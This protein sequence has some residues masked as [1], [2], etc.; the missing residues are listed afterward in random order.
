MSASAASTIYHTKRR[1]VE[2]NLERALSEAVAPPGRETQVDRQGGSPAGSDRLRKPAGGPRPMDAGPARRRDGQADL[3]HE[4]LSRETVRRR[5]TDADLK[6]C[7]TGRCGASRRSTPGLTSPAWRTCSISMS[8]GAGPRS[9]PAGRCVDDEPNPAHRGEVRRPIP[10]TPGRSSAT[11]GL[12][13]DGTANLFVFLD[14]NRPWRKVQVTARRTAIDF[15]VC[16]PNSLTSIIRK[17]NASAS[18]STMCRP[19]RPV[20]YYQAF[21][22]EQARHLLRRHELH[23]VPKHSA[24]DMV[25]IEIGVLAGQC[26][27]RRIRS[28]PRLTAEVAASGKASAMAPKPASTGASQPKRP[29]PKWGEPIR[30]PQ[31]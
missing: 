8:R 4:S 1:F 25:E 27:D 9:G 6:P 16:M 5:F 13:R 30:G 24:G 14:A 19:I 17:P 15:A 23:Y 26:L 11:T 22:A 10:P 7:A 18:C 29:A 31:T 28:Y 3:R 20:R 21:P 12:R 2:G